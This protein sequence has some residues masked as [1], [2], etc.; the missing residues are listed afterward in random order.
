MTDVKQK[1]SISAV[2]SLLSG[3]T[4]GEFAVD[5]DELCDETRTSVKSEIPAKHP[6]GDM[7]EIL[8]F[9]DFRD[10]ARLQKIACEKIRLWQFADRPENEMGDMDDLADSIK[11][12]GQQVPALVRRKGDGFELIF[13]NRRWRACS[14]L[15]IDLLCRIVP[16]LD[17][18][19]AAAL[20]TLENLDRQDLS[21]YARALSF[22]KMLENKVF[23]TELQLSENLRIPRATVNDILSYTRL[24]HDVAIQLKDIHKISRRL[25]VKLTSIAKNSNNAIYL[26][27]LIQKINSGEVTSTNIDSA[28]EKIKSLHNHKK[29]ETKTFSELDVRVKKN[30]DGSIKLTID[31]P[32]KFV[33]PI[34]LVRDGI[35][36]IFI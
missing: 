20:Q 2:A 33:K 27:D 19:T 15:K 9:S 11:M 13:G 7:R 6:S 5:I 23:D 4:L 25:V 8:S 34:D 10:D 29:I 3:S 16:N 14:Q 12:H 32:K 21:D 24:P 30:S 36:K 31:V 35:K 1:K 28:F 22:K 18:K 26:F 17:D